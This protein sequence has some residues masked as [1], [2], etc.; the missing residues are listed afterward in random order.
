[1]QLEIQS[2]ASQ[3]LA[4]VPISS[5]CFYILQSDVFF[6]FKKIKRDKY[7]WLV[8]Y[9]KELISKLH[10][11]WSRLFKRRLA[12]CEA[13]RSERS[14][15]RGAQLICQRSNICSSSYRSHF[16]CKRGFFVFFAYNQFFFCI[17]PTLSAFCQHIAAWQ[18]LWS[19]FHTW[20]L[21]NFHIR[22]TVMSDIN[23]IKARCCRWRCSLLVE[24]FEW[25]YQLVSYRMTVS[26]LVLLII[27]S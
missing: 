7:T 5:F 22:R 18:S 25:R 19:G 6:E 3:L 4:R 8:S 27:P 1:M 14:E 20:I 26:F 10:N 13:Q 24:K 17:Q 23:H 2:T 21:Y 12:Y 16:A 15:L 11:A 9:P